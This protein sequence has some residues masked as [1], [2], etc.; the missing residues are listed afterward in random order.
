M[1]KHGFPIALAIILVITLGWGIYQYKEKNDYHTYLDMHF[2]RQFYELIGH[3]ENVQINLSKA[4]ISASDMNIAQFLNDTTS[5][6]YMAQEKLTQ[7]PFHHGGIRDTERFLSQLG[8]YCTAMANKSLNGIALD[9]NELHTMMELR[10]YAN[11]L[12]EQLIELQQQIVKGGV[13]FGDLR[14][15]GNKSL[16]RVENQMKNFGLISFEERMQEYPELIYDGPFSDHLKDVKP[17]LAGK[18]IS[19][20]EAVNII[21]DAFEKHKYSNIRVTG[22]IKNQ[23]IDGYYIS[24][25][26]GNTSG[27]HEAT[28]AVSKIGGEIIW[29]MDPVL[30][31]KNNINKKDAIKKAEDFLRRIGFN[32]M[33][34]TYS[35]EDEG[36][37]V[38]NFAYEQDGVLIYS[39]LVKVKLA[40]DDGDIIGFEAQGYLTNHHERNVEKPKISEEEARK[41]LSD[42]VQEENARLA[43]IPIAGG[44]EVLTYEFKVKSDEDYYLIYIDADTGQQRK[45]LLMVNQ[46]NGTLVI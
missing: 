28:A 31:S 30:S 17:K 27:R 15:E 5:Q 36:Q 23:P 10:N 3:V 34:A 11:H 2:Q 44:K 9:E 24:I 25:S 1:R 37:M 32:N 8:D 40:L 6:S 14:R 45:V 38:I 4:M 26:D 46:E 19:E 42:R 7:L 13:N 20:K 33:E 35:M 39:D 12:S 16:K 22:N 21:S 43:I 41:K 29:Y 18:K